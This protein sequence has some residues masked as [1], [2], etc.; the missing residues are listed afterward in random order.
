MCQEYNCLFDMAILG[1]P[2]IKLLSMPVISCLK[3]HSVLKIYGV[4]W[5]IELYYI[6]NSKPIL[7]KNVLYQ[8][9]RHFLLHS[10]V[11][12]QGRPTWRMQRNH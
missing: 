9:K 4:L 11:L 10:L 2:D 8:L 7:S 5:L 1:S 12:R 6:I 3:K